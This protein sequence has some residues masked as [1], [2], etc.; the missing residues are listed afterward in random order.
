MPVDFKNSETARNLMR[1]FAGESQARTRYAFAAGEAKRQGL[2][3][4]EAVFNFTA[5]QERAHAKVFYNHL[6]ELAGQNIKVDGSYPVDISGTVLE[7]LRFA[8]HNE[9][10]EHDQVYTSFG[11][12]A[13]SEGFHQIAASF[14][15]IAEIEKVHGDRFGAFA[16]LMEQNKLFVSDFQCKWMCLNC[17]HIYDG[18]KAPEICPV[19]GHNKGFFI[20]LELAPFGV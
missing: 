15:N 14:R 20:R 5:D 1:A 3:V 8:Q 12:C 13:E 10:E 11:E 19:C 9:L 2:H 6:K 18:T 7:L 17:G 16:D 4:I